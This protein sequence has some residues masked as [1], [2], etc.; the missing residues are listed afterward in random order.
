MIS[1]AVSVK[2]IEAEFVIKETSLLTRQ[3][4]VASSILLSDYFRA[5]VYTLTA[6]SRVKLTTTYRGLKSTINYVFSS[7]FA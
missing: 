4:S 7:N 3:F 6:K 5:L 2:L 1:S